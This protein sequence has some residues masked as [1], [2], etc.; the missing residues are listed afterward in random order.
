VVESLLFIG[1]VAVYAVSTRA[2]DKVGSIGF[3]AFVGML[4]LAYV[5]S[6]LSAPPESQ[7][8]IGAGAM[9]GWVFLLW[10]HWFDRHREVRG[11]AVARAG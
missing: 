1:G 7:T 2:R 8:A 4:V 5:S 6:L 11:Q 9:V 3:W 10:V